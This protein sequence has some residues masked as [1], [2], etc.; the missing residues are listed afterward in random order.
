M[1]QPNKNKLLEETLPATILAWQKNRGRGKISLNIDMLVGS[2]EPT[3]GYLSSTVKLKHN[4][5]EV[6]DHHSVIDKI[7]LLYCSASFS[8]RRLTTQ[9]VQTKSF[10][11]SPNRCARRYLP[12]NQGQITSRDS[13]QSSSSRYNK[14]TLPSSFFQPKCSA[15]R[16]CHTSLI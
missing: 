8:R 5:Y 16:R 1:T 11:C 13:A 3:L 7:S 12:P 10:H 9:Y 2:G 14:Y 6:T 15:R 4:S